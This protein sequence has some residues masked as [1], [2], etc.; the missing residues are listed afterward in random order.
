MITVEITTYDTGT[1][2]VAVLDP[3][4]TDQGIILTERMGDFYTVVSGEVHED[5]TVLD[6][7]CEQ[8]GERGCGL[9][10]VFKDYAEPSSTRPFT[11]YSLRNVLIETGNQVMLNSVDGGRSVAHCAR[12]LLDEGLYQ[13][14]TD[15]NVT[16]IED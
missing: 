2:C 11:E 12:C 6:P 7:C 4:H 14:D 13:V 8:L 5:E 1:K 15:G 9:E 10:L 16:R 3:T